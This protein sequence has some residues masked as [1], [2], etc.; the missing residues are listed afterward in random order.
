VAVRLKQQAKD[1]ELFPSLGANAETNGKI[2][3][4]M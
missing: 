2:K 4:S 3:P 1:E